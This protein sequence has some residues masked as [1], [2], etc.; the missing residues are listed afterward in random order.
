MVSGESLG[1]VSVELEMEEMLGGKLVHHGG[2]VVHATNGSHV[3]GGEVGVAS[4][5]VP[6]FEQLGCE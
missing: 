1:V 6:V 3:L 2:K 5:S 4:C